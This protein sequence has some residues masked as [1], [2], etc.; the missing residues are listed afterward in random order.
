M[1]ATSYAEYSGVLA[2]R[3]T[4]PALSLLFSVSRG[5]HAMRRVRIYIYVLHTRGLVL[6]FREQRV[7]NLVS[8]SRAGR[9]E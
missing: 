9:L 1:L 7:A 4:G 6:D 2:T 3:R 8:F 5:G